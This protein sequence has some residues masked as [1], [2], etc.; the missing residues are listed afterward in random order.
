[1]TTPI[2]TSVPVTAAR[3]G[4]PYRYQVT[5]TAGS[6]EEMDDLKLA[7]AALND[8]MTSYDQA[9]AAIRTYLV[10]VRDAINVILGE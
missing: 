5:A 10:Q 9:E 1:M 6:E 8:A 4:E 2:I 3:V 7:L